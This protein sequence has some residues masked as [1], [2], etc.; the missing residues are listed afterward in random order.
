MDFRR[1]YSRAA[2]APAPQHKF[3]VGQE[4]RY[5]RGAADRVSREMEKSLFSGPFEVSRLLPASGIEFQYRLKNLATGQE[6]IASEAE[7]ALVGDQAAPPR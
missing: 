2:G 5:L 6:R 7:I 4:V 1:R 3:R